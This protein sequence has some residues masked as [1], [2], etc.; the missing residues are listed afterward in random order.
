MPIR[1][2][3]ITITNGVRQTAA[4][5]TAGRSPSVARMLFLD[6][7]AITSERD[8]PLQAVRGC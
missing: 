3:Q 6:F 2:P 4:L 7:P 8:A 5:E 1:Q